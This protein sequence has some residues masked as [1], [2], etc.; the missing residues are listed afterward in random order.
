[1]PTINQILD[2]YTYKADRQLLN[3]IEQIRY[4]IR[5]TVSQD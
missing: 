4:R 3:I 5:I 1:M 2:E